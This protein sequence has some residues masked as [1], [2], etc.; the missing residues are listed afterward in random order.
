MKKAAVILAATALTVIISFAAPAAEKVILTTLDWAPYIGQDLKNQ[1]YVAEV[2]RESFAR[3]G[4]EVDF[5][6]RP[7]ARTVMLAKEAKYVPE[8][9]QVAGYFPEYYGEQIKEYAVFSDPFPGGPLGFFQRKG[10]GITYNNLKDL[11]AYDIGIVRGYV[12]TAE[13]DS[14]AFLKKDEAKDDLTNIK[15]LLAGRIDLMV[16]DMAATT[17]YKAKTT[18]SGMIE[19]IDPPLEKKDLYVCFSKKLPNHLELQREF[20]RGLQQIKQDGTL[21]L[22]LKRHGF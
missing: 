6:Y 9:G 11:A 18:E 14:A 12:N 22:I 15:K 13:F 10:A 19:F 5:I 21:D 1:G 2:V 17:H 3:A 4:Y 7:W 20:N 16:A 8:K